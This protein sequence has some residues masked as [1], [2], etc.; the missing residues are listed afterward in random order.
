MCGGSSARKPRNHSRM[1]D[2][3]GVLMWHEF[4]EIMILEMR[5]EVVFEMVASRFMN[6]GTSLALAP[7]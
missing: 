3:G 5:N 7:E 4:R 1:E 6:N 2:S